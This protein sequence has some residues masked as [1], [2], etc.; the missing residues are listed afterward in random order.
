LKV[1][2]I[3]QGSDWLPDQEKVAINLCLRASKIIDLPDE[4]EIEFVK[5]PPSVYG[6]TLLYGRFKNRFRI[7]DCLSPKE[8]IKPVV[9]ELIHI[10]QVHIGRLKAMRDGTYIWDGRQYKNTD[11]N[12]LENSEYRNLPWEQDVENMMDSILNRII[13]QT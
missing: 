4:I 8:I 9:H 11:P 5:L 2:F 3:Y 1:R 10:H 13:T 6:E 7:N 12:L